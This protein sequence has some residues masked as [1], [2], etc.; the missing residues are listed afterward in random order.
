MLNDTIIH[1]ERELYLTLLAWAQQQPNAYEWLTKLP[2]WLN[3]I[4][5]KANYAH[6]PAYQA[7][8]ARLPNLI[9]DNVDLNSD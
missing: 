8:V 6:A 9:V 1:A 2:T 4:K 3:D 7:S 5:D